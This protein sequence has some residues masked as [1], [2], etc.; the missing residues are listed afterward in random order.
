VSTVLFVCAQIAG[1]SQIGQ[2]LFERAAGD[3]H[4]NGLMRR[5]AFV[6][7]L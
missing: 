6:T 4:R 1:C 7:G 5:F 2:A 3:E